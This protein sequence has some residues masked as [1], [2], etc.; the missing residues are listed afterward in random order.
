[1]VKSWVQ[2]AGCDTYVGYVGL[3]N[4]FRDSLPLP[5]KYKGNRANNL[6]PIY[7]DDLK[8]W[9]LEQSWGIEATEGLESDDWISIEQY[10]GWQKFKKTKNKEDL[11]CGVT[12]DKDHNSIYGL[13]YNPDKMTEPKI[14]HGLGELYCNKRGNA[15]KMEG[16]GTKWLIAQHPLGS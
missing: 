12:T 1:M 7:V 13:S 15:W 5:D 16:W 2:G 4:S 9:F 8:H 11:V 14:I 6:K 10:A 3:E